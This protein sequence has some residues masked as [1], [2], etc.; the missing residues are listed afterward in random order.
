VSR[1]ALLDVSLLVALFNP[2][3]MHH[4]IAHD[5]F[6]DNE[7]EGWATCPV[8]QNGFVR[9]LSNPTT[10]V[11]INRP[12][13]LVDRLRQFCSSKH[14]Q[15]WPDSLSFTD[16]KLFNPS[17]IRGYR[18]VTDVYLLGLAK[19]MGGHLATL[20]GGIPIGAVVGAT[21]KTLTVISPMG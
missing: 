8:T 14:H 12:S 21:R 11:S 3:H 9:V 10:E 19:K 16:P 2:G 1:V 15:F 18:Q 13:D 4:E 17:L 6:A 20:D 7:A 5:W